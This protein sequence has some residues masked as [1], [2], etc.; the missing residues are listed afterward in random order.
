M[1]VAKGETMKTKVDWGMILKFAVFGW[2]AIVIPV[3][4]FRLHW[5]LGVFVVL[6]EIGLGA[7]IKRI[8]DES[9]TEVN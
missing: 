5:E 3:D 1:Y 2:F 9:K 8:V 4:A 7:E 6:V